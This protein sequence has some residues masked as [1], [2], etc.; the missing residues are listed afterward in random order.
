MFHM[1][2]IFY[3]WMNAYYYMPF[4]G[5]GSA[6]YTA[7]HTV[8]LIFTSQ[9]WQHLLATTSYTMTD[10]YSIM[11]CTIIKATTAT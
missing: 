1:L 4:T 3:E 6:T 2:Y 9:Q 10:T 5:N 11:Y 8:T 7:L